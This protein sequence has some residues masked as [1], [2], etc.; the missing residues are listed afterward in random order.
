MKILILDWVTV[1]YWIYAPF[2]SKLFQ[3]TFMGGSSD[4][5][6]WYFYMFALVL[7][8][9]VVAQLWNTFTRLHAVVR[10]YEIHSYAVGFE[11]VDREYHS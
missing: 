6:N 3:T 4:S 10:K 7:A 2:L 5:E 1:Q 11:Q 8:R 9:Y